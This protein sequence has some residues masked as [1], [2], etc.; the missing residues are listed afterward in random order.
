MKNVFKPLSLFVASVLMLSCGGSN[1]EKQEEKDPG[2]MDKISTA[3]SAV[4]N[5]S[6]YEEYAKE[7]EKRMNE[8]K[9]LTP[10]SNED[11]KS[12]FPDQINGLK[13][14]SYAAGELSAMG[15]SSGSASYNLK[16]SEKNFSV[17]IYDGAGEAASA[18]LSLLYMSFNA[19]VEKE[20]ENGFEKM[21][22]YKDSKA[23][24]KQNKYGES[25]NSEIQWIENK[26]FVVTLKGNGYTY[27]ELSEIQKELDFSGLK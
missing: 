22:N 6:K 14:K 2:L 24:V 12:V 4:K 16:D 20:T 7:M 9:S 17:D 27:E 8:L 21:V 5:L 19:D 10:V 11:L 26:R 15:V 25:V 23:L 1:S 3:T 13:R 18:M